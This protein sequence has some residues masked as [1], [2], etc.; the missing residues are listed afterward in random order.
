MLKDVK[1]WVKSCD[2]CARYK[3][4]HCA[5]P[6]LLKPLPIPS[7]AW[8]EAFMDFIERLPKT[9]GKNV[10]LVVVCRLTKL[11]HFLPLSHPF[12]ATTVAHLFMENIYRLH[13][14]LRVIVSL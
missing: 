6:G 11:A 14:I 10:I 3:G 9:K 1:N 12:S 5:Y 13:G 7:Q 4:E 2:V 8:Q